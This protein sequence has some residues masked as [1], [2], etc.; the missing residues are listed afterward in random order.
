MIGG[1]NFSHQVAPAMFQAV[2]NLSDMA[3]MLIEFRSL[4]GYD[5][6]LIMI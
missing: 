6:I 3:K 2:K 4:E 5:H 1:I